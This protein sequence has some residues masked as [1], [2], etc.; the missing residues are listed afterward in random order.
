MNQESP[1]ADIEEVKKL[2]YSPEA[3][4]PLE[5]LWHR[6]TF[7]VLDD[8]ANKWLNSLGILPEYR[9][10]NAGALRICFLGHYL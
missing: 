2:Y 6:K 10:L 5:D 8:T 7:E 9:L 4:W 1:K 3:V